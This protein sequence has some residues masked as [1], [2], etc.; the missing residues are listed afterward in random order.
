M[1]VSILMTALLSAGCTDAGGGGDRRLSDSVVP[2]SVDPLGCKTQTFVTGTVSR[3]TSCSYSGRATIGEVE[4]QVEARPPAH[5][6]VHTDV[7][8]SSTQILWDKRDVGIS[9]TIGPTAASVDLP[10]YVEAA[11]RRARPG[12]IFVVVDVVRRN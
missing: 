9:T 12:F 8:Q 5:G 7:G 4:G 10:P 6:T 11:N 3:L 2:S 1:A